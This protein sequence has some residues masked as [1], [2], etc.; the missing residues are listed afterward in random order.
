MRQ[1]SRS[2]TDNEKSKKFRCI[3]TGI[4]LSLSIVIS[5][6]VGLVFLLLSDYNN[7]CGCGGNGG[8]D[9]A[10]DV[11][12]I[13]S[14]VAVYLHFFPETADKIKCVVVKV[15]VTVLVYL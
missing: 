8:N 2:A 3:C 4:F 5:V 1:E 11:D 9:P 14:G 10:Y 12:R 15:S 6:V 13:V 7:H